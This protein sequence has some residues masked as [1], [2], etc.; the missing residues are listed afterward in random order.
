M[1]FYKENVEVNSRERIETM[2][3]LQF[4][5]S[6]YSSLYMQ[7]ILFIFIHARGRGE[8]T[9]VGTVVTVRPEGA[10]RVADVRAP[11]CQVGWMVAGS[12]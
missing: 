2:I 11:A 1:H 12:K 10:K 4:I 6:F 9:P 8:R 3:Q 7:V 5:H